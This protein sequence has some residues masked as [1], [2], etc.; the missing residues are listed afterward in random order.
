ML[1]SENAGGVGGIARNFSRPKIRGCRPGGAVYWTEPTSTG[2][3]TIRGE[4]R[5]SCKFSLG[6]DNYRQDPTFAQAIR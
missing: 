6:E 5:S 1:T 4:K 3:G 2:E